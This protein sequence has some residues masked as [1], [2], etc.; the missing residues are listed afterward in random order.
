M[1]GLYQKRATGPGAIASLCTGFVVQVGLVILDLVKTAPMSPSFLESIHPLFMGH[2]VIVAMLISGVVFL[3]VS[4]VTR[5][6]AKVNLAPFF[7]E[8]TEESGMEDTALFPG[9]VEQA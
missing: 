6:S 1:G 4:L 9:Q 3:G 2:G 8:K 7:K 5:P